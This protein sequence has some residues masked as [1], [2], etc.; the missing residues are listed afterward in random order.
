[1]S[2]ILSPPAHDQPHESIPGYHRPQIY[3]RG[4]TLGEWHSHP[5]YAMLISR[6]V[7]SSVS[8]LNDVYPADVIGSTLETANLRQRA[9]I[10]VSLA[11]PASR[12]RLLDLEPRMAE[13]LP[14]MA[15]Y[16]DESAIPRFNRD[17]TIVVYRALELV[18]RYGGTRELEELNSLR[19]KY[20]NARKPAT[21]KDDIGDIEKAISLTKGMATEMLVEGFF[22][23]TRDTI[24][25]EA[26]LR[27]QR[28]MERY[29]ET[30]SGLN[31]LREMAIRQSIA[32]ESTNRPMPN[33]GPKPAHPARS[34]H[35]TTSNRPR[36]RTVLAPRQR[37]PGRHRLATA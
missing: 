19:A 26:E 35:V 21:Y 37:T 24:Q 3:D 5:E 12:R 13:W 6:A 14:E 20:S 17:E 10:S 7:E 29:E 27:R 36:G 2:D 1:M 30:W 16:P 23:W 15:K 11:S 22:P 9:Y 25:R 34:R 4:D 33:N 32:R 28:D 18:A 8:N 31:V